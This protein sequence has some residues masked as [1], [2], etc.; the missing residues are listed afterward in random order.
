MIINNYNNNDDDDNDTSGVV[1]YKCVCRSC[2]TLLST[3]HNSYN[4]I[5]PST[6]A[7]VGVAN[8]L[9]GTVVT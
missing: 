7:N 1:I 4:S 2:C 5:T 9:L 8:K 6:P 3:L